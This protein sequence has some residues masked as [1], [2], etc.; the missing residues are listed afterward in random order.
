MKEIS[1]F[2]WNVGAEAAIGFKE[3]RFTTDSEATENS[4]NFSQL[5]TNFVST[6]M[7][8]AAAHFLSH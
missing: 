2:V 8:F 3:F 7:S 6:Q 4:S 5:I 1:E